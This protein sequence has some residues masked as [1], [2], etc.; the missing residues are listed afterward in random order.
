M[1]ALVTIEIGAKNEVL[2]PVYPLPCLPSWSKPLSYRKLPILSG[3][4]ISSV[5]NSTIFFLK[6][7]QNFYRGNCLGSPHTG[8]GPTGH[9]TD[10]RA[11]VGQQTPNSWPTD[12][13]QLA[14]RR[15]TVGQ[16][17]PNSWQTDIQQLA[18]RHPTVGKQTPNSW[19]T[20]TQ[21]LDN[22]RPTGIGYSAI[23][24]FTLMG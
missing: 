3:Q 4:I 6:W 21:Q 15:P 2:D 18:N 19:Q 13:Q 5:K 10:G 8:Y 23:V 12:T 24:H 16:Q 7:Q 20:D 17:T 22:D 9:I 1:R 14:N 11:K